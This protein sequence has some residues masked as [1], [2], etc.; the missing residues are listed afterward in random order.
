M[1]A[2]VP[3]AIV[4]VFSSTAYEGNPL[5]VVDNTSANLSTDQMKLITRQFNLSETTFFSR[6]QD[7]SA[8][9]ALRSF[10]PDGREVFGAGHNILG[11]WWHLANSGLL[12]LKKGQGLEGLGTEIYNFRQLLGGEISNVKVIRMQGS[13]SISLRQSPPGLGNKHPDPAALAVAIQLTPDDIG[14]PGAPNMQPQVV[15][16][17]T[18]RH[19]HVP[20]RSIEV[21]NRAVVQRD[22]LL[23]QLKLVDD[24]AYG[25]FLFATI[26]GEKNKYQARFFSPGMNGEDP[27]TGSAAGPLS[28]LLCDNHL[29]DVD[30][31]VGRIQVLQGLQVGRE[32]E[33]SVALHVQQDDGKE[34][35]DVDLE[36]TGVEVAK[37][38]MKVPSVDMRF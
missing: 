30:N 1:A 23:E 24:G 10:L 34:R 6:P 25:L 32:C 38:D 7:S 19:L 18:T 8:D 37:G 12:D 17:S 15:S 35:L 4:D 9:F 22:K 20:L 13:L 11:V 27:A 33:I 16:T 36:G 26:Q 21:L 31:G 5:A 14:L 28:A 2:T 3:Y 29:L